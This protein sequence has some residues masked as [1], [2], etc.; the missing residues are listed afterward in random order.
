VFALY[1]G[2][3]FGL[4]TTGGQSYLIASVPASS[5][6]LGSAAYFIGSTLG[7]SLGNTLSGPLVDKFGFHA[8]GSW[9]VVA[10]LVITLGTASLL[11]VPTGEGR[12]RRQRAENERSFTEI[13]KRREVQLLMALRFFPT[14]YWGV[15]TFL[16]PLLIFR[17]AGTKAAATHYGAISLVIAACFQLLTGRLC[18]RFGRPRPMLVAAALVALSALLLAAGARSLTGLYLFGIMGAAS[19]WSL[20]TTMPGLVADVSTPSEKGRILGA[21][22][23]CWSAGMLGGN[24]TGGALVARSAT[25]AFGV[26]AAAA[27]LAAVTAVALYFC[28]GSSEKSLTTSAACGAS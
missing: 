12:R 16:I 22:H 1:S 24:L 13:L 28:L 15:A 3:A 10:T 6:S 7:N 4:S 19:A 9:M 14:F 11:P 21:T 26:G 25:L 23:F 8:L 5:L 27:A 2:A 17:A 18:D 20:S